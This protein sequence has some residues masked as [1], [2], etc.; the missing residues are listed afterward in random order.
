MDFD[1]P[2]G[3]KQ[4][5]R[6]EIEQQALKFVRRAPNIKT[7]R[8]FGE[9]MLK[10]CIEAHDVID[11]KWSHLPLDAPWDAEGIEFVPRIAIWSDDED[12]LD[13][14]MDEEMLNDG[15]DGDADDQQDGDQD[16]AEPD[17]GPNEDDNEPENDEEEEEEEE[18]EDNGY[19]DG[20]GM[21]FGAGVAV[22]MLMSVA[23]QRGGAQRTKRCVAKFLQGFGHTVAIE[24]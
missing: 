2:C 13:S 24:G 18:D 21:G 17:N 20:F 12:D 8:F 16:M 19:G 9:S 15:W 7:L 11:D 23:A 1:A 10:N 14:D 4:G 22:G 3:T 5:H 6:L